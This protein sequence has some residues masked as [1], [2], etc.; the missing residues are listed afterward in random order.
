M[1]TI[2]AGYLAEARDNGTSVDFHVFWDF[3][4]VARDKQRWRMICY[5]TE[6][7][8]IRFLVLANLLH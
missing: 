3:L 6:G 2:G 4:T 1:K 5:V 7:D 8:S